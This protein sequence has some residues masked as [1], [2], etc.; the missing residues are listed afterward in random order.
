M[1]KNNIYSGNERIINDM[2]RSIFFF[3]LFFIRS[4][5]LSARLMCMCV[6]AVSKNNYSNI[7]IKWVNQ[8]NERKKRR[9]KINRCHSSSHQQHGYRLA[10]ICINIYFKA[11]YLTKW[12]ISRYP[13]RSFCVFVWVCVCNRFR[14]T[15]TH[16]FFGSSVLMEIF[17]RLNKT[18]DR[19]K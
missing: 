16:S 15:R 3:K 1:D 12:L 2:M 18:R 11:C 14:W 7:R 17:P 9:N 19:L 6:C 5:T 8:P 10:I 4:L 13:S